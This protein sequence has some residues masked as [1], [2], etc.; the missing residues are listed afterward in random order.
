MVTFPIAFP[1]LTPATGSF[2]LV[3]S[4]SS[5]TSPFT[6]KQQVY[7]FTGDRWEGQVTFPPLTQAQAGE[8]QAFFLQLEGM[9]GTFLYGDPNYL[10]QSP[11]GLATGSP[12]VMGAGQTGNSLI[13]DGLSNNLTGWLKKGDYIQIGTGSAS[14]LHQVSEDVN[15][16]GSG[17]ATIPIYPAIRTSPADNAAIVVT[18]AKGCFRLASSSG[19]WQ[20]GEANLYNISFSYIEAITE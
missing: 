15:T 7:R 8:I 19:E 2:K 11:R 9:Y 6:F 4:V 20:I 13:V 16:N 12:L 17:Q 5:S 18:G 10:A 14:R 1:S 3:R